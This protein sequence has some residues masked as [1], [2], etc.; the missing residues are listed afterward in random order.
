MSWHTK[1]SAAASTTPSKAQPASPWLR[2]R[3]LLPPP[4]PARMLAV[5]TLV[6][7]FGDGL[8][9]VG[10]VLF[11]I[12][13][14]GLSAGEVALGLTAAEVVGLAASVPLGSLADRRARV[15]PARCGACR[16]RHGSAARR[17]LRRSAGS[18]VARATLA[19]LVVYSNFLDAGS[20][21]EE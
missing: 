11:F 9:A 2:L 16:D 19:G 5:A 1:V 13:G 8:F 7:R 10:G 17:G 20:A 15:A 6:N 4:G 12:R 14:L 18:M 21:Y 3:R